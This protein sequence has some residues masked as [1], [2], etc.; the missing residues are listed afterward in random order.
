MQ[1]RVFTLPREMNP[2]Q[3]TQEQSEGPPKTTRVSGVPPFPLLSSPHRPVLP[4]VPPYCQ[5][6][7]GFRSLWRFPE[8]YLKDRQTVSPRM[9]DSREV[10]VLA[11]SSLPKSP[12]HSANQ[13]IWAPRKNFAP[14]A[15]AQKPEVAPWSERGWEERL[16]RAEVIACVKASRQKERGVVREF[17][18]ILNLQR[19]NFKFYSY[20]R[21]LFESHLIYEIFWDLCCS[22]SSPLLRIC[23]IYY[24]IAW[25]DVSF[26]R[27]FCS[28]LVSHEHSFIEI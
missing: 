26:Y 8:E 24:P 2:F 9:S 18:A 23:D 4:L 28:F 5:W 12:S 1:E 22:L 6:Q 7:R 21:V 20:F 15:A 13:A 16:F 11:K 19:S 10:F 3:S 17:Q 14:P 27:D 25:L